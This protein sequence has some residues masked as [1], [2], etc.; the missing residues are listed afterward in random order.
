[1]KRTHSPRFAIA[2]LLRS[3]FVF[4]FSSPLMSA[5][6]LPIYQL[7]GVLEWNTASGADR[8][9]LDGETMSMLFEI[10]DP[11]PNN[12]ADPNGT[13]SEYQGMAALSLGGVTVDISSAVVAFFHSNSGQDDIANFILYP[14]SGDPLYFY[15]AVHLLPD[16]NAGAVLEPPVYPAGS[17][18]LAFFLVPGPNPD[19][20]A[21]NATYAVSGYSFRS[22]AVPVPGTLILITSGLFGLCFTRR[23]VQRS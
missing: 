21:D 11:T 10:T 16:S 12:V 4:L 15:P 20:A 2:W 8:F 6:A 14:N 13:Q 1:M 5:F 19:I 7:D 17:D 22:S 23:P 18:K 3:A 9:N